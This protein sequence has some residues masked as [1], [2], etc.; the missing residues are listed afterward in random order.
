M[1]VVRVS[2]AAFS[3]LSIFPVTA[4][5]LSF[6]PQASIDPPLPALGPLKQ[7]SASTQRRQKKDWI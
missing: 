5:C 3:V 4:F 2:A 7:A 6:A 1:S